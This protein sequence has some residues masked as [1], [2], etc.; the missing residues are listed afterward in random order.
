MATDLVPLNQEENEFTSIDTGDTEIDN[1]FF[2][3]STTF[4]DIIHAYINCVIFNHYDTKHKLIPE[5][6]VLI[7]A[8][9][10]DAVGPR[11][12]LHSK[13]KDI[14]HN[15]ET[16]DKCAQEL[17]LCTSHSEQKLI[18]NTIWQMVS[19]PKRYD[20]AAMRKLMQDERNAIFNS[21][22][23]IW[24]PNPKCIRIMEFNNLFLQF[25]DSIEK[26]II[27]MN[28]L[29]QNLA[30]IHIRR[31]KIV[32]DAHGQ[33]NKLEDIISIMNDNDI[34]YNT[35]IQNYVIPSE[36]L[37]DIYVSDELMDWLADTEQRWNLMLRISKC[38][39]GLNGFYDQVGTISITEKEVNEVECRLKATYVL[40]A[41]E[42]HRCCK[43]V[44]L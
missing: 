2:V 27:S 44:V 28:T 36:C 34:D 30:Q 7:C 21:L 32:M 37:Q 17:I 20:L 22:A 33:I 31:I 3:L 14:D 41:A 8:K 24:N 6:V 9:Y 12:K 43:C 16:I 25:K 4:M 40:Q 39:D 5:D 38:I 23:R 10:I 15:I 13:L 42:V 29:H 35:F 19:Y 11:N 26:Y 18:H 1:E